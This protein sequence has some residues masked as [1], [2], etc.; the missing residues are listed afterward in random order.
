[1]TSLLEAVDKVKYPDGY[2]HCFEGTRLSA[3]HCA[4]CHRTQPCGARTVKRVRT[5]WAVATIKWDDE[6]W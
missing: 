6:F 5:K 4:M 1:M 2:L 3:L